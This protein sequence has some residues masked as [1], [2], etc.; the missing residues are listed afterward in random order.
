MDTREIYEHFAAIIGDILESE[1]DREYLLYPEDTWSH[2]CKCD[3]H[4][5]ITSGCQRCVLVDADYDWV[6]KFDISEDRDCETE[7][8]IYRD[9]V[10]ADLAGC[11]TECGFIGTY[12][13]DEA[14]VVLNLYAFRRMRCDVLD[15]A[16]AEEERALRSHNPR[17]PL[18]R[19]SMKVAAAVLRSWGSEVFDRLTDFCFAHDI[20]DL[21]TGNVG[22][23]EE[24][25]IVLID[26]AG[27]HH[28]D[29]AD[30]D[31]SYEEEEEESEDYTASI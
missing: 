6:V 4:V 8:A 11:F 10:A 26:F 17:S 27:Y 15:A 14:G 1:E 9:A 19:R 29:G 2:E 23:D 22:Y 24:N 16:S 3:A 31:T 12:S 7:L 5:S 21:H 18:Y 28:S 25:R 30:I 20:N 13:D